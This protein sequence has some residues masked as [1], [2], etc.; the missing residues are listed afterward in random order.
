MAASDASSSCGPQPK[1]HPAPP[2][3]Q[4]PKP[5]VVISSP[6]LP[7]GR[8]GSSSAIVVLLSRGQDNV[9]SSAPRA[10]MGRAGSR[11]EACMDTG[12]RRWIKGGG[13]ALLGSGFLSRVDRVAAMQAAG[14]SS[15]T[16]TLGS[17][18]RTGRPIHGAAG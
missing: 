5:T 17:Q 9:S 3:A 7:R 6:L 4:A 16:R 1:A 2:I 15:L 8:V 14:P 11:K 12:R 13:L 18:A 10:A